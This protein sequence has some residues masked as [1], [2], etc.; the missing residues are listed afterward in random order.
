MAVD[1]EF[2]RH[3]RA[4]RGHARFRSPERAGAVRAA[5]RRREDDSSPAHR[6]A[7][8]SRVLLGRDPASVGV[9]ADAGRCRA[10]LQEEVFGRM[11]VHDLPPADRVACFCKPPPRTTPPADGFTMRTSPR[12]RAQ[13]APASSSPTTG[14]T[15]SPTL[16]HGIRVETPAEFLRAL[17]GA[18]GLR[19]IDGMQKHH[20]HIRR[21]ARSQRRPHRA[22]PRRRAPRH[23]DR[24]DLRVCRRSAADLG[25]RRLRA[26][27]HHARLRIARRGRSASS[28]SSG[29]R[30]SR[31]R[32]SRR[33]CGRRSSRPRT[34]SSSSTSASAFRA[35]SS[36]LI[37]DIIERRKAGGASTLTQQLARKLFLTDEKTPGAEDQGSAPR[38]PDREAL[39]EARDLHALL[40]PDVLR[41]RRLRR[42]GGLAAVLRQVGE[43]PDASRRPRSSPASSRATCARART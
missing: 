13:P 43:G 40:Q 5:R 11:A 15:S 41:P 35:S 1:D 21:H 37:K 30:S 7:L 26:E 29:A 17:K 39:H 22:L 9:Q 20:G 6:L 23:R 25:A 36:T 31:T 18:A 27:H 2:P 16:R 8:L 10:L 19:S 38:H 32:R 12:W 3:E 4:A 14:A 24:R 33:T 28:R 34:L 42:R